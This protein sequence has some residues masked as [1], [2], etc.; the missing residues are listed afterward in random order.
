MAIIT[1]GTLLRTGLVTVVAAVA[2]GLLGTSTLAPDTESVRLHQVLSTFREEGQ[3]FIETFAPLSYFFAGFSAH[4][5]T[6][7]EAGCRIV[8]ASALLARLEL[9]SGHTSL[10]LVVVCLVSL[11]HSL[12]INVSCHEANALSTSQ[13]LGNTLSLLAFLSCWSLRPSRLWR[14][15]QGMG[16]IEAVIVIALCLGTHGSDSV[17]CLGVVTLTNISNFL[18]NIADRSRRVTISTLTH[19]YRYF[20]RMAIVL[21]TFVVIFSVTFPLQETAAGGNYNLRYLPAQLRR[22]LRPSIPNYHPGLAKVNDLQLSFHGLVPAA[23]VSL[24]VP[25]AGFLWTDPFT[26]DVF[27]SD[28]RSSADKGNSTG[29]RGL[30]SNEADV[31]HLME[32]QERILFSDQFNIVGKFSFLP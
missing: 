11:P 17:F 6:C 23:P 29:L 28:F 7:V 31:E 24:Y 18:A 15:L 9:C 2:V 20:Q 32:E 5:L 22:D 19:V 14:A 30:H 4:A 13:T 12:W 26:W 25:H 3:L 1:Y 27:S 10:P 21:G 8:A 16:G